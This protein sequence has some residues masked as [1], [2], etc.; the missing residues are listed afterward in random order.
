[1]NP[2]VGQRLLW[3]LDRYRGDNGS[4]NCPLLCRIR[5][6]LAT[7]QLK[8]A[9]DATVARHDSLRSV[10]AGGGRKLVQTVR[11]PAPTELI[12]V[13]L[14]TA[15]DPQAVVDEAIAAELRTRIDPSR[16]PL[17][18]RL[19]RLA[20][21]D[22]V[23]CVNMHH[24]VTD[25]WSLGIIFEDLCAALELAAGQ[26]RPM[27]GLGWQYG[28]FVAAQEA[29]LAGDGKRRLDGYWRG[30]LAGMRLPA[31]PLAPEQPGRAGRQ[32]ALA[33]GVIGPDVVA[34][35]RQLARAERTT[36][37]T[38]LLAAY[39]AML[40]RHTGDPDVCVATLFANRSR[41][42]TKR[43]VGFLANMVILRTRLVPDGTFAGQVRAAHAT[44]IGGFLHQ[45][46]PYQ[47][48]PL[49]T[50][51]AGQRADDVVFQ[52]L[53]DPV[54]TTTSAGLEIEVLVPEGVGSRFEFELVLVPDGHGFRVLLFYDV[55][56]LDAGF[57]EKFVGQF[58]QAAQ[59]VAKD[60]EAVLARSAAAGAEAH[61][62]YSPGGRAVQN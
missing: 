2:S 29:E 40:Y 60:P 5:G 21:D 25:S 9:L 45:A 27:P 62:P 20:D 1:M 22:H 17:R 14:G 19:W 8:A 55:G 34:G 7:H 38:V 28:D 11:D 49:S 61:A 33:R 12:E 48:L 3:F 18:V 36:L 43:T 50:G 16:C 56:R 30:Q 42:Q 13:D 4:L 37:F 6:P 23:L 47:M 39:Y 10:F 24:L 35:L 58:V 44:V 31:L 52:M 54:Y 15:A 57:A 41:P 51:H 32:T 26:N 59:T 46:L 53:A